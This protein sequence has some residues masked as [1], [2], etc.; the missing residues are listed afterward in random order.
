MSIKKKVASKSKHQEQPK[1]KVAPQSAAQDFL[2]D[3]DVKASNAALESGG[4]TLKIEKGRTPVYFTSSAY[5]S[6]NV[7]WVKGSS[8]KGDFRV[9]CGG[10][11]EGRGYA[12]DS[13]EICKWMSE[14]YDR[15]S[16]LQTSSPKKAQQ[17]RDTANRVHAKFEVL[18]VAAKG[19]LLT[20]K[21]KKTGKKRESADFD[22][23]QVGLLPLTKKQWQDFQALVDGEKYA[24]IESKKDL[25][26]RAIIID[27][28]NR[29]E[30]RYPTVEF[31]PSNKQQDC[32]VEY[33]KED[34]DVVSPFEIDKETIIEVAQM[35]RH[36][37][38]QTEEDAAYEDE[39]SLDEYLDDDKA[40]DDADDEPE[41]TDDDDTVD[42]DDEPDDFDDSFLEDDDDE[43]EEQ[44]KKKAAPQ[45]HKGA[46]KKFKGKADF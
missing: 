33:D 27:K 34:F 22:D 37:K 35:L 28:R 15:A 43:P 17:I 21:D 26:N 3:A 41:E 2:N 4:L 7:H 24:F 5:G 16:K 23:A 1:K 44:P 45:Q 14:V 8:G 20:V 9:V 38:K 42:T 11:L 40:D 12:P 6:G 13:C 18:F 32:P 19:E 25:F 10:G 46:Q 31:I 30:D 29:N 36:G 39:E